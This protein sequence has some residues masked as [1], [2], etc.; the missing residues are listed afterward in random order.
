[1][2]IAGILLNILLT[3]SCKSLV[4]KYLT[5]FKY[6]LLNIQVYTPTQWLL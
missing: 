5:Y 2:I 6:M 4:L 3:F 1:M